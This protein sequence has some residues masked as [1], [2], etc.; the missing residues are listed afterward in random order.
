MYVGKNPFCHASVLMGPPPGRCP[1]GRGGA[2]SA[3]EPSRRRGGEVSRL[4]RQRR[5]ARRDGRK[6][7]GE[8]LKIH[9]IFSARS[10]CRKKPV[11]A[12]ST[13]SSLAASPREAARLGV[14]QG[15]T[16]ETSKEQAS[17]SEPSERVSAPPDRVR[18]M[19]GRA[20]D[21]KLTPW[22]ERPTKVL[23]VWFSA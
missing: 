23:K 19:P 9:P 5:R 8:F 16:V 10:P 13:V 11:R 17:R 1:V 15:V 7:S 12:F 3:T 22:P 21:S 4:P 14:I 2:K 6:K 20:T 18:Y